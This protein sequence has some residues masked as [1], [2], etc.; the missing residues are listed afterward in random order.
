MGEVRP[1]YV[2][3][4]YPG[5]RDEEG[6]LLRYYVRE[7]GPDKIDRLRTQVRVGEGEIVTGQPPKWQALARDLSRYKIDAVIDRA[8]STELVELKSRVTHTAAGQLVAYSNLLAARPEERSAFTLT[9]VGFRAH[10]DV[11]DG[12]RGTGI[13]VHT[14]PRAD[15]TSSSR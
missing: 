3:R 10:P 11:E 2:R 7:I 12:L 13:R 5:L 6:R 9:A 15:R 4:S 8:A 1:P 14:I